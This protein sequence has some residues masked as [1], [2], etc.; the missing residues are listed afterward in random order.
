METPPDV[1]VRVGS[2]GYPASPPKI[3]YPSQMGIGLRLVNALIRGKKLSF[4]CESRNWISRLEPPLRVIGNENIPGAGP[5][6]VV[7]NHYSRHGFSA[8]WMV[9]ALSAV[10]PVEAHWIMAST[11]TFPDAFR[12]RT[13][14]P[15]SEWLFPK[16]ARVYG[17]TVMPPMPPRPQDI[18]ARA[19]AVRRVLAYARATPNPVIGLAPEGG[20][21]PKGVLQMPP[22]GVGR[23]ILHLI[24]L[25]LEIIPVGVF[26]EQD[27]LCLSFGECQQL[28][29][30]SGQRGEKLDQTVA[31]QVMS[32]I[33]ALLPKSLQGELLFDGP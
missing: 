28:N 5:C 10:L 2:G 21:A 23:F 14:T 8:W 12:A 15:F 32:W 13:L 19:Q 26:E 33:A 22:P 27:R 4:S 7:F 16:I 3:H 30:L 25:G 24:D 20:D 17:F 1:G 29:G 11:W 9:F 6:L 18:V 31:Q